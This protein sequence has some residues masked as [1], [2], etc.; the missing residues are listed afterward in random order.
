VPIP[1]IIR[2]VLT[3]LNDKVGEKVS[4]K[5]VNKITREDDKDGGGKP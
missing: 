4:D 2:R 3:A 5:I 1:G